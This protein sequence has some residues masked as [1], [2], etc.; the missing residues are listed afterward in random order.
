MNT[1]KEIFD[2]PWDFTVYLFNDETYVIELAFFEQIVDYTVFYLLTEEDIKHLDNV[3]YFF[4]LSNKIRAD[5]EKFKDREVQD[6]SIY[7]T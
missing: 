2:K 3:D 1:L 5:K 4:N 6:K 7:K